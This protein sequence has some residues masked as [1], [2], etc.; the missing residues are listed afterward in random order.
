M[1]K[2]LAN[3]IRTPEWAAGAQPA[4]LETCIEPNANPGL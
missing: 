1:T 4:E 3:S 2:L